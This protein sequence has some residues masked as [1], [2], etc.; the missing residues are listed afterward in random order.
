MPRLPHVLASL[1]VACPLLLA[2]CGGAGGEK[3]TSHRR[4]APDHRRPGRRDPET[5]RIGRTHHAGQPGR[6]S[7]RP[8]NI[9]K[10]EVQGGEADAG[11]TPM[12]Y[13]CGGRPTP[14]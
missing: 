10:G 6:H 3:A 5:Q 11:P 8:I 2:G 13:L 1:V 9:V 4:E 7:P 12:E 14:S